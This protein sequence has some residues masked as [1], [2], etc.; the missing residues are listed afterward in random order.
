MTNAERK[1][2]SFLTVYLPKDKDL[3]DLIWKQSQSGMSVSGQI[4]KLLSH[5][6]KALNLI[7]DEECDAIQNFKFHN[8]TNTRKDHQNSNYSLYV[9]KDLWWIVGR[10][11][12]NL[13]SKVKPTAVIPHPNRSRYIWHLFVEAFGG[14]TEEIKQAG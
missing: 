7:S 6:M 1:K 10:M 2:T 9:P 4:L 5:D 14:P 12:E 8:A 3:R 11:D 13:R